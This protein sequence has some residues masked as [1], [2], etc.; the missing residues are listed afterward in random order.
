VGKLLAFR[1]ALVYGLVGLSWT[2]FWNILCM[3]HSSSWGMNYNKLESALDILK[4][5][6]VKGEISKDE[7]ERIKKE[8]TE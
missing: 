3:R 8:I 6:Y 1:M 5:R 4:K 7:F 2:R